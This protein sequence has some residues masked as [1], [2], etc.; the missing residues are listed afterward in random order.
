MEIDSTVT[1]GDGRLT[2]GDGRLTAG[3]ALGATVFG[4][5]AAPPGT[6]PGVL[7]LLADSPLE[8]GGPADSLDTEM[9]ANPGAGINTMALAR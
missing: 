5:L 6:L 4:L 2:A 9:R 8:G 1:A 3:D 7:G